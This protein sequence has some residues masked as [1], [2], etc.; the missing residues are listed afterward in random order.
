MH[1]YVSGTDMGIVPAGVCWRPPCHCGHRL[2]ASGIPGPHATWQWDC[3][4]RYIEQCG[5]CPGFSNDGSK[6][7][8]EWLPGCEVLTRAAKDK[9]VELID[10][11]LLPLPS[12]PGALAP[13]FWK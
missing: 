9:W 5:F 13:D 7:P 10:R 11:H 3:P 12:K 6:D 8:A 2:S 4:L 1:V